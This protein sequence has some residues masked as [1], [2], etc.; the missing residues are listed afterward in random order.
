ML[1]EDVLSVNHGAVAVRFRYSLFIPAAPP[2][3]NHDSPTIECSRLSDV[4]FLCSGLSPCFKIESFSCC[5]PKVERMNGGGRTFER[6]K[7][8]KMMDSVLNVTL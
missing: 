1:L 5:V 7:S 6:T 4:L 2:L 3:P 8:D